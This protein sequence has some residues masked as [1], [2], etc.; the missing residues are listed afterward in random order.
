MPEPNLFCGRLVRLAAPRPEDAEAFA[1]WSEDPVYQRNLD[2]DYARPFTVQQMAG[3]HGSSG[4]DNTSVLFHLRTLTDDRLIGFMAI[5]S[6]EWNNGTCTIATGIGNPDY[7]G[8]GYG[9]DALRLIL[10]YAFN[11]LN[12]YRVGLDVIGN[13]TAAIRAY[14]RAGFR[15]EGRLRGAVNRDGGRTDR[16]LMGILVNEWRNLT[17]G[18]EHD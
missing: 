12:L 17:T 8:K 1:R 7:R 18:D 5:F 6:I 4:G 16:I 13:N 11:E 14:Q 9:S 2:T 3:R 10:N 15:E